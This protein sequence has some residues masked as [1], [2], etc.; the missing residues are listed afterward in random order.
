MSML[1]H[2]P[3]VLVRR[4]YAEIER[5]CNESEDGIT[6]DDFES[7]TLLAGRV[8]GPGLLSWA[9]GS[10][11]EFDDEIRAARSVWAWA[12]FP[13]DEAIDW[14][15]VLRWRLPE[16]PAP[17]RRRVYRAC[18]PDLVRRMAWTTSRPAAEHMLG[19]WHHRYSKRDATVW[20]MVV[21]ANRIVC[22]I[23]DHG[24]AGEHEILVDWRGEPPMQP[25]LLKR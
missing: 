14:H 8:H 9:L 6:L 11:A 13:E 20:T 23:A 18:T 12:D 5:L 10:F 17:R 24:R 4:A 2:D 7:L 22:H 16:D 19:Y 3:D 25:A 1:A 15:D 21:P